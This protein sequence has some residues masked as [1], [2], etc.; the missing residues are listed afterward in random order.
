M[1]FVEDEG[2]EGGPGAFPLKSMEEGSKASQ[3]GREAPEARKE[4]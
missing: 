4:E 3:E 2:S 1:L